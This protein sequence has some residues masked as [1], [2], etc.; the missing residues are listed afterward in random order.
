[1]ISTPRPPIDQDDA[2]NV[3]HGSPPPAEGQVTLANWRTA[4][5]NRWAFH[6]V[7]ELIVTAPIRRGE[8]RWA[9]PCKPRR[10]ERITFQD[11]DGNTH[12]LGRALAQSFTDGRARACAGG[13]MR[14]RC[15]G[16]R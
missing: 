13:L 14:C 1:M 2:M 6:H 15:T 8:A 5:F 10:I 11:R 12:Q 3:M 7:R 16:G 9:L 4:P